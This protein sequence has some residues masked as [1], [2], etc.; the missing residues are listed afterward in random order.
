MTYVEAMATRLRRISA[1][2]TL[3]A[4]SAFQLLA[5]GPIV[6]A[7]LSCI[8][9]ERN[10]RIVARMGDDVRSA[11]V[12][13]RSAG[14]TTPDTPL[15]R[16]YYI[17]FHHGA[18]DLYWAV[19]PQMAAGTPG[20]EY[21]IVTTDAR[22]QQT[23]TNHVVAPVVSGCSE[24]PL[25]PEEQTAANNLVIGL[26]HEGESP[27]PAGM[28]CKGIVGYITDDGQLK[29]NEP[30]RR[31]LLAAVPGA[32]GGAGAAGAGAATATAL[33]NT[34]LLV[35]GATALAAGSLAAYENSRSNKV[36]PAR[37]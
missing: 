30:C 8:A 36:S 26:T 28:S 13:F 10:P 27:V 25:T 9:P 12:M 35:L 18:G 21:W 4:F 7:P 1:L 5:Q 22:G 33:S 31:A 17:D 16:E 32:A 11:R 37:P 24:L 19:L 20:L 34:T 2:A 23:T 6:H 3:F 14:V 29:Q 15:H